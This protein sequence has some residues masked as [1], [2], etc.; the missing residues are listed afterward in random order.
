MPTGSVPHQAELLRRLRDEQGNLRA[1]LE[2]LST[3]PSNARTG[4]VMA[5][6]LDSYWVTAGLAGEA[7]HWLEVGLA[8]DAG[9]PTE[10]ALAMMMAARFA[11]LQERPD[12]G[13]AVARAGVTGGGGGR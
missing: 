3:D 12:D 9:D 13:T 7:R 11:C 6:D 8:R 2:F 5:A 4:L 10:R 1:A